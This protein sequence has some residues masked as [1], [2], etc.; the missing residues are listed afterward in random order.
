MH[1]SRLR[2]ASLRKAAGRWCTVA[3]AVVAAIF[4][5]MAATPSAIASQ[6][7]VPSIGVPDSAMS[8]ATVAT[9]RTPSAAAFSNPAGIVNLEAGSVSTSIGVPVGHSRL[10]TTTPPGYDTT[11]D[12]VAYSPEG[13]SVF[14][15]ESGLRWGFALYGSLGSTFDSDADPSV[16]VVQDF[17]SSAAVS[18]VSLMA[19]YPITDRLSAGVALSVLYG[20]L[21]LRYFQ[22]TQFAYTVRGAGVQ[23]IVGLRYRLT[24]NVALGLGFRTPG[25]I[26]ADGDE[27]V[28]PGNKQDVELNLDMPAQIFLGI[29]ADVTDRLHLGLSG[30]W[31]DASTFSD[32]NF[33]FEKTP[34]ASI[35]YIR[36]ASDEW[37]IAAGSDYKLT[38]TL[39]VSTGISY[40]DAIV[41]DTWVSPL[42]MDSDEWKFSAGASWILPGNFSDWTLDFAVGH[43]PTGRRNVSDSEAAIF[44]GRYTISGQ[45]YMI[46]LR[47]T[48]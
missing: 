16:G 46:G 32:S 34:E 19:A 28:S 2:A 42:L 20:E 12:F 47:T 38:E 36:S 5:A 21:H 1:S 7:L 24:D 33:R 6:L 40:A 35:P 17:K 41:P 14:E 18:N 22:T 23:A 9:P 27:R 25:M 44:P 8:G 11:S 3:R 13:G 26:W 4:A 39:S 45:I 43:S 10:H 37:R 48:L 30:R 29:N 15:T 31:T